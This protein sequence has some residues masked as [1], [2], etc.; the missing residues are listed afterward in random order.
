MKILLTYLS[1]FL[2]VLK[3]GKISHK[4]VRLAVVKT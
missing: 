3:Q 4:G 1:S 2:H